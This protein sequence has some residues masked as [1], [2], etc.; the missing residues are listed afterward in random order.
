[1]WSYLYIAHDCEGFSIFLQILKNP[2]YITLSYKEAAFEVWL[3]RGGKVCFNRQ[4]VKAKTI[5]LE[6]T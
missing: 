1:M 2:S 6:T 5:K 3:E 4:A